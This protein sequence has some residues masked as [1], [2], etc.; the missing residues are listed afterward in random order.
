MDDLK[1]KKG[2]KSKRGRRK[3]EGDIQDREI[4]R[5]RDKEGEIGKEHRGEKEEREKKERDKD[6][7]RNRKEARKKEC[8][9]N[10]MGYTEKKTKQVEGRLFHGSQAEHL[11]VSKHSYKIPDERHPS[12]PTSGQ[13]GIPASLLM[14]NL[15][16]QSIKV[17]AA[18]Q[19]HKNV[20]SVKITLVV[21]S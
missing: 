5:E 3:K 16:N 20:S 10:Q 13:T 14:H 15:P 21:F 7:K 1:T 12:Y 17:M 11:T 2:C 6:G 19:R 9:R 8:K 18:A 4:E